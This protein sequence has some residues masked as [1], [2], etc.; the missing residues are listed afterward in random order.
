MEGRNKRVH[1]TKGSRGRKLEREDYMQT[2][3]RDMVKGVDTHYVKKYNNNIHSR[4]FIH[5]N[6]LD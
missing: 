1:G 3:M 5:T 6:T 2:G 4:P